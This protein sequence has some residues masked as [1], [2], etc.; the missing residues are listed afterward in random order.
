MTNYEK[1]I[2]KIL[3]IVKNYIGIDA[4]TGKMIICGQTSCQK[5]AFYDTFDCTE[6]VKKWLYSEHQEPILD[7]VEK[8]YL[9]NMLRPFRKK[10]CYISKLYHSGT[11]MYYLFIKMVTECWNLPDFQK[12][13]MY[14][15]IALGEEY[16]L[17]ELGLFKNE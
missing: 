5:C 10:I 11:D 8:Q 13:K 15:N 6:K 17:E 1:Y 9:E 14:L 7:N 2:D 4:E 3:D 12:N 16:T